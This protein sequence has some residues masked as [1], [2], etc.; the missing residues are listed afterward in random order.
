[1]AWTT[2][3]VVSPSS[4]PTAADV[5]STVNRSVA[6]PSVG[7]TRP[8]GREPTIVGVRCRPTS[9]TWTDGGARSITHARSLA[10]RLPC[11]W[12]TSS[13]IRIRRSSVRASCST[14]NPI[15]A[16]SGRLARGASIGPLRYT[17]RA[18]TDER[19]GQLRREGH[20]R[21][22]GRFRLQPDDARRSAEVVDPL[23]HG[24]GLAPS[25]RCDDGLDPS[26][27]AGIKLRGEAGAGRSARRRPAGAAVPGRGRAPSRGLAVAAVALCDRRRCVL[28]VGN[29]RR[30]RPAG[31]RRSRLAH[32]VR[33]EMALL[34]HPAS[35]AA[36]PSTSLRWQRSARHHL[37]SVCQFHTDS[38]RIRTRRPGRIGPASEHRTRGADREGWG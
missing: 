7:P 38:D 4:S 24:R 29:R 34:R 1:M 5:S 2:F 10:A 25:G 17:L 26:S 9:A 28:V 19:G 23:P 21:T 14:S 6:T 22:V 27:A 15:V 18:E 32:W 35:G 16:S 3:S 12:W 31:V 13:T 8:L 11:T 37:R 20:R 33:V 30:G 36:T